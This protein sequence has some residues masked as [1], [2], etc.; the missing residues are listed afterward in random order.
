[1]GS[2]S[3]IATHPFTQTFTRIRA[4]QLCRRTD[5]ARHEFDDLQ[6]GMKQYLLERASTFN[7]ERGSAEAFITNL[8]NTWVAMELRRRGRLKRRGSHRNLSLNSTFVQC[9]DDYTALGNVMGDADQQRRQRTDK[10]TPID[11]FEMREGVAHV[12]KNLEP[13]DRAVL[14]YASKHGVAAAARNFNTSRR[15]INSILMRLRK[16]FENAGFGDD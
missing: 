13:S 4:Y 9:E 10:S 6:Q 8:V 7:P 16:R 5:F 15:Q 1:M 12:M 3:N 11:D 14:I 2:Q